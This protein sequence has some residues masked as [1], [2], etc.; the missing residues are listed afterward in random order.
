[1]GYHLLLWPKFKS[2]YKNTE[3]QARKTEDWK[4]AIYMFGCVLEQ[5]EPVVDDVTYVDHG[6]L[7]A[8]QQAPLK[9]LTNPNLI[10]SPI[11]T[12]Y[13]EQNALHVNTRPFDIRSGGRLFHRRNQRRYVGTDAIGRGEGRR[14]RKRTSRGRR[15]S[16]ELRGSCIGRRWRRPPR[17]RQRWWWWERW[18]YALSLREKRR[19]AEAKAKDADRC[20]EAAESAALGG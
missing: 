20:G 6:L 1:M 14:K 10:L 19:P 9:K 8:N 17:R 18:Y 4:Q 13:T 2:K 3:K 5:S 15:R 7:L 16:V 11:R 12:L